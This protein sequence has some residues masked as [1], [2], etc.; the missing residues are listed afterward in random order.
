MNAKMNKKICIKYR[1][2][3]TIC[4]VNDKIL[5][6]E[7]L[8]NEQAPCKI[9]QLMAQLYYSIRNIAVIIGSS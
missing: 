4:K 3:N 9:L 5:N 7:V 2:M 1:N 8:I 6:N